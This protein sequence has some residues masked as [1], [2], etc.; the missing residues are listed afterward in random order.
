MEYQEPAG[1]LRG[2]ELSGSEST[3]L[4][5]G[6]GRLGERGLEERSRRAHSQGHGMAGADTKTCA[7]S[8]DKVSLPLS[9]RAYRVSC[10][11]AGVS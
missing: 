2:L 3:N 1:S 8:E 11:W 7:S 4:R 9:L 5:R 6:P 10:E